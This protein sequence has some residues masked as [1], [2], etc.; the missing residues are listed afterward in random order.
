MGVVRRPRSR[1]P[2]SFVRLLPV[3]AD[4]LAE[5]AERPLRVA[6]ECAARPHEMRYGVDHLSVHIEL[7]LPGC[8]VA[9]PDRPRSP[10]AGESLQDTLVQ[11]IVAVHV[12]Q[13]P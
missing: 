4:V 5:G 2:D 11:G 12:I 3:P 1:L 13:N 7:A 8:R 6:V 10:V 9:D